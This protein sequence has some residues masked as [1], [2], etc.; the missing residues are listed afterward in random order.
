M[1]KTSCFVCLM[2][3]LAFMS[4]CKGRSGKA[5]EEKSEEIEFHE[6]DLS[7]DFTGSTCDNLLLSDIVEDVEY[8]QLE[9]TENGLVECYPRTKY[10]ITPN[11]IFTL[12]RFSKKEL[13][14]FD[15]TTGKFI[16]PIGQIGQGP[17]D[18][19]NPSGIYAE[20][21]NVYVVSS[22]HIYIYDKDGEHLSTIPI[23]SSGSTVSAINDE[24]LVYHPRQRP[25]ISEG[26]FGKWTSVNVIDF[27]GNVLSAKVDTLE[28]ITGG[29]YSLDFN[30]QRW[31]Y[32]GQL[33]FYN[34]PDE[35]VYAVTEEGI[36][37]RYHFN[38]GGN[39]WPVRAGSMKK[40]D[41]ECISFKAFKETG[42]Y[43]YIYWNQNQKAYF[44]RFDKNS[45][46][47][48]V[49][50]QE[51]FSGSLWQLFAFGPKNDIDGCGS[52]FGP[53][54]ISEDKLGSI[55]FEINPD[56]IDRVREALEKAENVKFPEKR[57][58][59]LKM[60]DERKEDDNPI[61]VIYKL[62]K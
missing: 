53:I 25:H 57:Q 10:A 33:N 42:D 31:Y 51:P 52:Y 21:N 49:Q 28:G 32:S 55:L 59:L 5:V 36:I 22:D 2:V 46:K 58:Q 44:A 1:K 11:D 27:E 30:P 39:E 50:E 62:K 9:T 16:S 37:P 48:D 47:L 23:L 61:L 60:L 56:N 35:T 41:V 40:E 12:N 26:V 17:E 3:F 13:F 24:R 7:K 43:L 4:A 54:D 34:E 38:L 19:M 29:I 45:G 18:M 20:K 15:R 8:V 14:R 6:I